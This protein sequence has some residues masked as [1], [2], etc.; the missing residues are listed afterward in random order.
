[1]ADLITV[2]QLEARLKEQFT[3]TALTQVQGLITDASA[4]VRHVARTTFPTSV[5]AV[6]V[7]VVAQMVRR[8]LDNPQEL[9]G[10]NIGGYGWQAMSQVTSASGGSLYVTRAERRLIREAAGR[11]AI[12]GIAF[13]T[14]LRDPHA[15]G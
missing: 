6:V 15:G 2:A 7:A 13:D 5:P 3:G 9:T 11:P 10:E 1:M 8:A 12:I 14:G 4:L